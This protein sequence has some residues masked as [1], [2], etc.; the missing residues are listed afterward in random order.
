LC[1]DESL[2]IAGSGD[3]VAVDFFERV[4]NRKG[5]NDGATLGGPATDALNEPAAGKRTGC[6]VNQHGSSLL[7]QGQAG[8]N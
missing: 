8:C 6:V 1:E 2:P 3:S 5:R 4:V 7:Y